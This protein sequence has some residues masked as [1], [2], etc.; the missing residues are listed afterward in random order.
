MK[1]ARYWNTTAFRL[2]WVYGALFL[3][4][5]SLLM[6]LVYW[7]TVGFMAR[8]IDFSLEARMHQLILLDGANLK[9]AVNGL[10]R[11]DFLHRGVYGY[12]DAQG[13]WLAGNLE[14]IPAGLHWNGVTDEHVYELRHEYDD[15]DVYQPAHE[16]MFIARMLPGG[17]RLLVGQNVE[18]FKHLRLIIE[19]ALVEGGTLVVIMGL[20]AGLYLSLRSLRRVREISANCERIAQ[21]D[22]S[23]RLDVSESHDELDMLASV[24]NAMLDR[25]GLLMDEVRNV[26]NNI[27]HDLRTP[28]TRLRT[29]LY[30]LQR[31]VDEEH[32]REMEG[33]LEDTDV[34]LSRFRALLRIA[35]IES[36]KRRVAF[37]KVSLIDI[38]QRVMEFYL[39]LTE[40][41]QLQLSFESSIE[42]SVDADDEL[43]FEAIANVLDNAIKF[44]PINGLIRLHLYRLQDRMVL[45]ILD[46]GP[47]IPDHEREAVLKRY[48]R[49][50]GSSGVEGHGLGL[51][52]VS[53]IM[54][55]HGFEFC[56]EKVEAG[57]L[58][59]IY[60][61][62]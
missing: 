41:K 12:F 57:A 42:M 34:V 43:L 44:S 55:L 6:G 56:F 49:S 3:M 50:S 39:P 15:K 25:V 17:R 1:V 47:G 40:E 30:R 7:R 38:L 14:R 22:L 48:Y 36:Q 35:E 45:D 10:V 19:E 53:A 51:S 32:A 54:N 5:V 46:Q 24:V 2:A 4:T 62:A 60:F 31:S 9:V 20:V 16:A 8:S 13:N 27:A 18:S 52:I 11:R 37:T 61:N 21:G 33:V 59:R 26:C 28:M 29:R 23:V 58:A